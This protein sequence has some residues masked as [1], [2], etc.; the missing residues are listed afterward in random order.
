MKSKEEEEEKKKR[1]VGGK[2]G[3]AERLSMYYIGLGRTC[4]YYFSV[5]LFQKID[6]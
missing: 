4:L 5:G 6:K 2:G 3:C 1:I